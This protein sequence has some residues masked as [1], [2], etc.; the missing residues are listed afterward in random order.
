MADRKDKIK[1]I[2]LEPVSPLVQELIKTQ[3]SRE[4]IDL[5]RAQTADDAAG[6]ALTFLPCMLVASLQDNK[7]IPAVVN[8]LKKVER[9]IKYG[10]LKSMITS[11]VKN[12]QLSNLVTGMGVTDFIEEPAPARTLVFKSNL[13]IKA[14]ET[15][16]KQEEAKLK[17][18]EKTVFKKDQDKI[19]GGD[20]EAAKTKSKE[21]LTLGEDM[22]LFKNAGAKKSGKKLTLEAEGPDPASGEWVQHE[23]KGNAKTSWRW[24][25]NED[26][27]KPAAEQKKDGWVHEGEKPVFNPQA[28]KWQLTSEKPDLSFQ[29][30]GKKVAAKV[31]T[32]A[33]GEVE[34][35]EDS[36]Q[37]EENLNKI[38]LKWNPAAAKKPAAT[39]AQPAKPE[40]EK[41][42]PAFNN[43]TG[44]PKEKTEHQKNLDLKPE[45]KKESKELQ[46]KDKKPKD[47]KELS[48]KETEEKKEGEKEA[49]EL[50]FKD[51]K[52]PQK[53]AKDFIAEKEDASAPQGKDS[54]V[55]KSAV[56][57]GAE[58]ALY[59]EKLEKQK[60][61]LEKGEKS[62][63]W[64]S[65]KGDFK[66]HLTEDEKTEASASK[67]EKTAETEVEGD[68][69]RE[70]KLKKKPGESKLDK[71]KRLMEKFD[72][73]E[74]EPESDS[75]TLK[76]KKK[77]PEED[78][79]A[80]L[81][82]LKEKA[83][84]DKKEMMV[85]LQDE[86]AKPLPET[87]PKEEAE[88]I[89]KELGLEDPAL[90]D[91]ELA[92]K[93][94]LNKL[95]NLKE[96]LKDV[97]TDLT[98]IEEIAN[99]KEELEA[100]EQ[101]EEAE[102]TWSKQQLDGARV[103]E[104]NF[105]ARDS[106]LEEAEETEAQKK[107]K[108]QS[109]EKVKRE[110]PP[111][112]PEFFKEEREVLPLGAAWESTG[113]F[114][115][116]LDAATHYKG[117]QDLQAILPLWVYE[118][119]FKPELLSKIK[120][121][122][123]YTRLPVQAKT[124]AEVPLEVVDYLNA[125]KKE[126]E[127]NTKKD[128]RADRL[129][130]LK[131]SLKGEEDS[132]SED[133]EVKK[134]ATYKEKIE[135][136]E[137]KK[138]KLKEKMAEGK[139]VFQEKEQ[140]KKKRAE[141]TDPLE[142][143]KERLGKKDEQEAEEPEAEAGDVE[144]AGDEEESSTAGSAK[145]KKGNEE[146]DK[147]ARFAALKAKLGADAK[148]ED[149]ADSPSPQTEVEAPSKLTEVSKKS[150]AL[151][152]FFERRKEREKED[153]NSPALANENEEPRSP[154]DPKIAYLGIYV[155]LSDAVYLNREFPRTAERLARA[156]AGS[157]DQCHVLFVAATGDEKVG[158]VLGSSSGDYSL[159]QALDVS[160]GKFYTIELKGKDKEILGYLCLEKTGSR[161]EFS[162][163]EKDALEKTGEMV[164][165]IWDARKADIK[166][167]KAA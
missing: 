138:E 51:K 142:A 55:Q 122:R 6:L 54:A 5:E 63:G 108:A 8:L 157:I 158:T 93:H 7:D 10:R 113:K 165:Q 34:I 28:K 88:A 89:R 44:G 58:K 159:N 139:S 120:K 167:G 17:A 106:D 2:V 27:A 121:W 33:K 87:L 23:D 38:A 144:E 94:K 66:N 82:R 130:A 118:G 83:Q 124:V 137:K 68:L 104:R 141:E 128:D 105:S 103:K 145:K 62:L 107:K 110:V 25:P 47:P 30:D 150:A 115:V 41:N 46:F 61:S 48:L 163:N 116:F 45:E 50:N 32:S 13:Q 79:A 143:L 127:K 59:Q 152:K 91:K 134:P 97:D 160:G 95:K 90:S 96:R 92:R 117:F 3:S 24:V 52:K 112:E 84:K 42:D 36:K 131:D 53:A 111:G 1:I 77:K 100:V 114:Y 31:S 20:G 75:P 125:L 164:A 132:D 56:D 43:K 22:F 12:K 161:N 146:D 129:A 126:T 102:N 123:F 148:A 21:A 85:A 29:K 156:I 81:A 86:L 49:K 35:A 109:A 73:E 151:Q 39:A 40:A 16:R 57:A 98:T 14:V 133:G 136:I 153:Q 76:Q 80:R 26:K 135:E 67:K 147:R 19:S 64:E 69:G 99:D 166:K 71:L 74:E 154:K 119:E 60:S 4:D 149:E 9:G 78:R 18:Q 101:A 65:E 72:E 140:E 70:K 162:E 155:A 37:A 15:I 11:K